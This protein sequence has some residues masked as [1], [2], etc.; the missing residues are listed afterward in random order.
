MLTAG[1][2]GLRFF[3]MSTLKPIGG[4]RTTS[5]QEIGSLI[6]KDIELFLFGDNSTLYILTEEMMLAKS[7]GIN[8]LI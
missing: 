2:D 4:W 1:G 6:E 3:D 7:Q 8:I 5:I